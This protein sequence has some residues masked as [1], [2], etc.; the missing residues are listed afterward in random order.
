MNTLLASGQPLAVRAE[1]ER[2]DVAFAVLPLPPIPNYKVRRPGVRDGLVYDISAVASQAIIKADMRTAP[3]TY[4]HQ[5][6]MA[7]VS[8]PIPISS[9]IY[10]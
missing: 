8:S 6:T 2:L 7:V 3:A 4:F 1:H 9:A 10:R 5:L